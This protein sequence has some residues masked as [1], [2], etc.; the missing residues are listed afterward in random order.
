MPT[1][2]YECDTC[3]Q[4]FEEYQSITA[5]PLTKCVKPGCPG[6]VRRL[7]SPGAG[8]IFKGSGF[9]STDYRSDSYKKAAASEKSSADSS[10]KT[11]ESKPSGA[12]A[13]KPSGASPTS[14]AGGK[15]AS[16]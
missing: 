5:P 1:Y 14:T 6:A 3:G 9:Y 2:E 7:I 12:P 4:V 13:A 8:F 11:T 16:S 15:T 10:G